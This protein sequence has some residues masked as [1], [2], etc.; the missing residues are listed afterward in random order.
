MQLG[1]RLAQACHGLHTLGRVGSLQY[2]AQARQSS[3]P[4]VAAVRLGAESKERADSFTAEANRT[5]ERLRS[6]A[7]EIRTKAEEE[8]ARV[9]REAE[10]KASVL[11]A[12]A[13]TEP[14]RMSCGATAALP[15]DARNSSSKTWL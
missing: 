14:A 2:A 13:A 10:E 9:V 1:R 6:E 7:E 15:V 12:A 8:A 11:T 4:G 5:A 3:G